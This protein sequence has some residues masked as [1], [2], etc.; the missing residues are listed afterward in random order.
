MQSQDDGAGDQV[1]WKLSP[2]AE[3]LQEAHHVSALSNNALVRPN[4]NQI[5][6]S[7]DGLSGVPLAA[8]PTKR[9]RNELHSLTKTSLNG[10]INS[11]Y[12]LKRIN[13]C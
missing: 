13:K 8:N 11:Y 5:L 6:R 2:T 7:S 4:R 3:R 1:E 10:F 9:V 12:Y